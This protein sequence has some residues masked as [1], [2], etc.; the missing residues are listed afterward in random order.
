MAIIAYSF[1]GS[2]LIS[3]FLL[4]WWQER[5]YPFWIL[6]GL[7]GLATVLSM[8]KKFAAAAVLAGMLTAFV[9][10]ARTTHRET[11]NTV[12]FYARGNTVT[13]EGIVAD[14][15]DRRPLQTKYTIA[16]SS[17]VDGSGTTITPLLGK[18]LVTDHRL[19]PEFFYGDTVRVLGK[20]ERPSAIET[21]RY[22]RYLSRYDIYAVMYRGT[23]TPIPIPN[24]NP[25]P[26]PNPISTLYTL[27]T[28][29]EHRLNRLFPEP[30]A[31]FMAGLLTG[32][33]RGIP[34]NLTTIFNITGLTHIVAISGYNITIVIVF[35]GSLLFWLPPRIRF[36]PAVGAIVLFT[37]FVGA[38]AAVVRAAIMGILG[39]LAL[40]MNRIG[41]AR[42]SLLWAAFF[43]VV[44]N[45]KILWYDA[46]F[47]LSFL[48]VIGLME[49]SPLLGPLFRRV[50]E[51]FAIRES[52]QMTVAAQ[53]AAVPLVA[54]LFGRVSLI[55]PVANLLVA[56]L[57][58]LAMIFGSFGT[59]LSYIS[60]PLGQMVAYLGWACLEWIIR[61]AEFSAAIPLASVNIA[62]HPGM[63][64][65]YYGILTG[66]LAHRR[67]KPPANVE[68]K[69]IHMRQNHHSYR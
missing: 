31:S 32:T 48:A 6:I 60:L 33:R 20:L 5:S 42:L 23:I 21:F 11:P 13:I 52:L 62:L 64:L 57:I 24:P 25:I 50:P 27:K 12:D 18:V 36:Y 8:R 4:Q 37:L 40:Q 43:M 59:L 35:I 47:Q 41:T 67:L 61:V 45:P 19:W 3:I 1:L 15:P 30:H 66:I 56:P 17:L 26:I 14:E 46:G 28:R 9:A 2:C 38:G 58:P 7:C 16:V 34:E 68:V 10:V 51:T 63:L 49:L 65:S 55:A 44:W 69:T 29:F 39:L 54:M 22:D 53:I